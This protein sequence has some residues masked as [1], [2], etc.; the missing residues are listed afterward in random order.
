MGGWF[1]NYVLT[2][3]G[4][5]RWCDGEKRI[6]TSMAPVKEWKDCP[7]CAGTGNEPDFGRSKTIF[8]GR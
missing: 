5:C 3:D 6:F 2:L 4:N 1:K 8:E 7:R